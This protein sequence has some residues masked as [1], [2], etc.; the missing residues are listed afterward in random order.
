MSANPISDGAVDIFP[1]FTSAVNRNQDK[2]PGRAVHLGTE[3]R[4]TLCGMDKVH[5]HLLWNSS[6]PIHDLEGFLSADPDDVLCRTCRSIAR[7]LIN[8]N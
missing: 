3:E 8:G 2:G 4:W 6:Y 1:V 5:P 7:S